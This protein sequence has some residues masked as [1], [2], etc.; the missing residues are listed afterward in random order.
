MYIYTYI[1]KELLWAVPPL[2]SSVPLPEA[3]ELDGSTY[4]LSCSS[5]QR[6][7][8]LF[9]G[10]AGATLPVWGAL[11]PL[12]PSS[13]ATT[14]VGPPSPAYQ[15]G[16]GSPTGSQLHHSPPP[17]E[18]SPISNPNSAQMFLHIIPAS[19]LWRS[20]HAVPESFPPLLCAG[21]PQRDLCPAC[22]CWGPVWCS[23]PRSLC[24]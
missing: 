2:Y 5:G 12:L 21:L 3:Q 6:S 10:S 20:M 4:F 22:T 14:T 7:L 17:L 9:P 19:W 18:V 11:V 1:F 23:R 24:A 16:S 8:M 15:S 13:V